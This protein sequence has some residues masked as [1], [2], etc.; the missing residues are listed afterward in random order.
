MKIALAPH[1]G[2]AAGVFLRRPPQQ[3]DT[4]ELPAAAAGEL[5]RLTTAAMTAAAPAQSERPLPDAMS[6][7]I[8]IEDGGRQTALKQ[9]D[10][11]MSP[12]FADL[13][14]WLQGHFAMK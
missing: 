4:A 8:T 5:T 11:A 7:T 3:V 14:G 1:G 6:Y 12:A 10:A 2:L 9:S 13:L